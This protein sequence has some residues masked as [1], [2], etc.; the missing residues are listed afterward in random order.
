MLG[1]ASIQTTE[2]YAQVRDLERNNPAK[3]LGGPVRAALEKNN[4][5]SDNVHYRKGNTAQ[6]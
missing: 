2:I 4:G 3:H 5:S 6:I 1:H